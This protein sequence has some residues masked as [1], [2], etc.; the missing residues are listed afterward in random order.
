M[1][2]IFID[3]SL[4]NLYLELGCEVP[5]NLTPPPP[6]G[7]VLVFRCDHCEVQWM[8]FFGGR[9]GVFDRTLFLI[10]VKSLTVLWKSAEQLL[11]LWGAQHSKAL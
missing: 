10:P 9:E 4:L 2:A 3:A 1:I 11:S 5:R 8:D 7:E 6:Q